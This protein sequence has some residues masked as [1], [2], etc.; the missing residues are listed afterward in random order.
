MGQ[1]VSSG[2]WST[3]PNH[4]PPHPPHL[5]LCRRIVL[6]KRNGLTET[7]FGLIVSCDVWVGV[8]GAHREPITTL[9]RGVLKDTGASTP[10][11][12]SGCCSLGGLGAVLLTGFQ[13]RP[14]L[15]SRQRSRREAP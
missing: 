8:D 11:Q 12:A 14:F 4:P 13:V 10:A 15:F 5:T 3:P 7:E 6:A 9:R 1:V 2:R